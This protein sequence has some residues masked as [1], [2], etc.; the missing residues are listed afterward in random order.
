MK[1]QDIFA[2]EGL[3]KS[4]SFKEGVA[5]EVKK[6]SITDALELFT[7]TYKDEGDVL[8]DRVPTLVYAELFNKEYVKV[9]TRQ[10]LFK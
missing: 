4:Q 1:F 7:V 6:N 8:P 10:S 3:Y 2:A 5:F 9:F